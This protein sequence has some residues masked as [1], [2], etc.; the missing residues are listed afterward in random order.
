V[1]E[2]GVVSIA[3]PDPPAL[4]DGVV[5]L[6]PWVE[7]DIPFLIEVFKDPQILHWTA[8]PPDVTEDQILEGIR[9]NK[10]SFRNGTAAVFAIQDYDTSQALGQV[11]LVHIDHGMQS[12]EVIYWLAAEA[13]GRGA[14]T[15]AVRL[16]CEW[17]FSAV[18]LRRLNLFTIVGNAASER[19]AERAG[20][21]RNGVKRAY[22]EINGK[23]RDM[24]AFSL[25]APNN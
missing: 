5:M 15:R 22:R 12:A 10:E 6:R 16:L 24:T 21:S 20:F 14:A 25:V 1:S 19:V 8:T 18:N 4:S 23:K 13:R 2:S 9:S 11:G 17:A 3:I 7:S